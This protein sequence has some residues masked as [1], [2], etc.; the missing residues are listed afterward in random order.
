VG[1]TAKQRATT[2]LTGTTT[3]SPADTLATI[4]AACGTVKGGGASL[5]TTGIRNLGAQ[6]N[7]NSE[8][9]DTLRLSISSGKRLVELC[10]F[11]ATV[12]TDGPRTRVRVGGLDAY[13]TQQKKLLMLIPI[14]PK[15]IFGMAPYKKVLEGI[16]AAITA[17][18]PAAQLTIQQP[19]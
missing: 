11:S 17:Q 4:K 7:I 2:A 10:S 13:K 8:S 3:L 16:Q 15:Q 12:S 18:D 14:E 5:L 6:V 9:A 19:G 1:I